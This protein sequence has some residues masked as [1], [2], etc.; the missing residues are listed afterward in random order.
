MVFKSLHNSGI[1]TSQK[2]KPGTGHEARYEILVCS[3]M[4]CLFNNSEGHEIEYW[5]TLSDCSSDTG[6]NKGKRP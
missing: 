6:P 1:Y 2:S 3:R 5:V 4:K